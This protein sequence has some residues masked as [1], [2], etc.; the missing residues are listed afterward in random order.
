MAA[1]ISGQEGLGRDQVQ[2]DGRCYGSLAS[3]LSS[4]FS[5]R[6]LW[7]EV[8]TATQGWEFPLLQEYSITLQG[9]FQGVVA[10]K[11]RPTRS[12]EFT[13]KGRPEIPERMRGHSHCSCSCIPGRFSMKPVGLP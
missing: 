11:S 10:V 2:V 5:G 4:C 9:T 13:E 6:G 1:H 12:P 3:L 8:G 7:T